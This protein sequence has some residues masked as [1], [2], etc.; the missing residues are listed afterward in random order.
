MI[1]TRYHEEKK[2]IKNEVYFKNTRHH[3]Q[4]VQGK[5]CYVTCTSLTLKTIK[6]KTSL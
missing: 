4:T 6:I 2:N 3:P 5:V 1:S